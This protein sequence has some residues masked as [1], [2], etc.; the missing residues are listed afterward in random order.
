MET[1]RFRR[2]ACESKGGGK[3]EGGTWWRY[4]AWQ[5]FAGWTY[6]D[7]LSKNKKTGLVIWL[8]ILWLC[9][10]V[11]WCYRP[12]WND[13]PCAVTALL[14]KDKR[15]AGLGQ[16]GRRDWSKGGASRQALISKSKDSLLHLEQTKQNGLTWFDCLTLFDYIYFWLLLTGGEQEEIK[17][18]RQA[19]EDDRVLWVVPLSSSKT[20]KWA[21]R[22]I[23][24]MFAI[25]C[26]CSFAGIECRNGRNA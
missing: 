18:Q 11:P 2:G 6:M 12:V 1:W 10:I 9:H 7:S 21:R 17:A 23:I 8:N 14:K 25:V 13:W 4:G 3:G 5:I 20:V 16:A 19:I 26:L 15:H 22:C 24:W